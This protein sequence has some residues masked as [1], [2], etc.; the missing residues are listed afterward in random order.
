MVEMEYLDWSSKQP[1]L[2]AA[3]DSKHLMF[4]L[5][6]WAFAVPSLSASGIVRKEDVNQ[7]YEM[8][9]MEAPL[10]GMVNYMGNALP[11]FDFSWDWEREIKGE[12]LILLGHAPRQLGFW[13][14]KLPK[15]TKMQSHYDSLSLDSFRIPKGVQRLASGAWHLRK[16]EVDS[17]L[18]EWVVELASYDELMG[19]FKLN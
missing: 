9:G 5:R 12:V 19:R 3:E 2:K 13:V 4:E 11:V 14:D 7:L 17:A 1:A 18:P 15:S 10:Q 16:K 8:P 6:G